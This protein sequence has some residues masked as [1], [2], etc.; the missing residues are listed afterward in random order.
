MIF[1][2]NK[3]VRVTIQLLILNYSPRKRFEYWHND[4]EQ[5]K[6]NQFL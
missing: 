2:H 4:S 5:G 6:Y 3:P 1:K